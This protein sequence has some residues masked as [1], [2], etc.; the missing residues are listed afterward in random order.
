MPPKNR[1]GTGSGS[2]D[3]TSSVDS[4]LGIQGLRDFMERRSPE[5]A[6]VPIPD[7]VAERAPT[8]EPDDRTTLRWADLQGR[9]TTFHAAGQRSDGSWFVDTWQKG[10]QWAREN[11]STIQDVAEVLG[12]QI[13]QAAGRI[14]QTEHPVVGATITASGVAL[15]MATGARKL[16]R[17][18][19]SAVQTGSG[20]DALKALAGAINT[21]T[22]VAAGYSY[23]PNVPPNTA[24]RLQGAH[25]IGIGAGA[26]A[27]G[28]TAQQQQA[29]ASTL[30]TAIPMTTMP[31]GQTLPAGSSGQYQNYPAQYQQYQNYPA[32]YQQYQQQS[33]QNYSRPLNT[34][35]AS[36][37][38][39]SSY[40]P[41]YTSYSTPTYASYNTPSSSTN[42]AYYAPS[43]SGQGYSQGYGPGSSGTQP[44]SQTSGYSAQGSAQQRGGRRGPAGGGGGG[45]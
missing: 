17:Y 19:T 20:G 12:P 16:Y 1:D 24:L 10:K 8:Q 25:N 32:Q 5:A 28:P 40:N 4:Y 7:N 36:N 14:T 31:P 33:A 6:I 30:P 13:I 42:P 9:N 21:G 39:P 23:L 37:T 22:A 3:S 45:R 18:G 15:E 43:S 26:L 35:P 38:Q 27:L 41:S 44:S 2:D 34:A 11:S 29:A